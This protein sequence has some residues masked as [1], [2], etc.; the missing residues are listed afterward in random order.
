LSVTLR[1]QR[2][3]RCSARRW[4]RTAPRSLRRS[5][6][7]TTSPHFVGSSTWEGGTG[8]FLADILVKNPNASGV[9]FDLPDVV[10]E[11]P[12]LL[13][14]SGVAEHCEVVAGSLFEPVPREGDLYVLRA[15][16]HDWDDV[17]ATAILATCR[18]AMGA[19][20]RLVIV[21]RVLPDK[22]E[23]GREADS[24]LLDL[25]M[26]TNTP[27]GRERTEAEFRA[28]LA[29]ANFAATKF[30]RPPLPFGSSRRD[31]FDV[32]RP[33]RATLFRRGIRPAARSRIAR[34]RGRSKATRDAGQGGAAAGLRIRDEDDRRR[35][36]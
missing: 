21:E 27:G 32:A 23:A 22:A 2:S 14:A 11:A 25:E 34:Q 33:V 19:G 36:S 35:G 18:R 1:T 4:L 20:A 10:A 28:I 26:L 31:R 12:P 7:H 5:S 8:R 15:I 6:P 13:A 17:R 29:A 24:Y 9:L 16:L 3:G 30:V